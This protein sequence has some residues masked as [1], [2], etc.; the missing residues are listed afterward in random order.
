MQNPSAAAARMNP[1]EIKVYEIAR[2]TFFA[3]IR[4]GP[5][6]NGCYPQKLLGHLTVPY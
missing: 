4:P 2:M 3:A 5:I 1:I 6:Q